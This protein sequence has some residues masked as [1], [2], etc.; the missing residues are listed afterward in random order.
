[1][2]LNYLKIAARNIR[3]HLGYSFINFAGLALGIASSILILVWV[4][5]EIG[6][7]RFHEK[8]D[9]LYVVRTIQHYGSQTVT[10]TGSVPALGPALKKEF[11]EVRNAAR[12]SNGQARYL[13][14]FGDKQFRETVQMADPELFE[15]FTFPLVR[16]NLR[17]LFASKDVMV[18]SESAAGRIFGKADPVGKTLTVDK[19]YDF[20]V[21]GVMKD[22]PANSTIRFDIWMPLEMT[23]RLYRPNYLDTWFNMAF[24]TYVELAPGT[25][26]AAFN[27]KIFDR[28]RQ[29][30]PQTI[31]E[32]L[33]YP[34]RDLYLKI[35]GRQESVRIFSAIAVLIL[36]IACIN[37]MNLTTA[38]S[39][40]RS[41]EVELRK[42]VGAD[43]RQLMRQF[44]GESLIFTFISL[45]L[46][47]GVI[48]LVLPA[49]RNLTAKSLTMTDL[50]QPSILASIVGIAF[51]T[52]I[53]AG[54]Y[55]SV[56]LSSFRPAAV[57]KGLGG[58]E[59][60]GIFFRKSLV[61]FQFTLTAVLMIGTL[62]IYSQVRYMKTK[63]LGFDREHLLYTP[64]EGVLGANVE[65]FKQELLGIPGVRSASA[66]THSPTGIYSN[67]QDWNWEGRDPNVNPLVTY[68][69]VDPDF[70]ETFQMNLAKGETFRAQ[71]SVTTPDVIIN[72]RLAAIIGSPDVIG[73]RLSQ[74]TRNMRIIG[75]VKDFHFKPVSQ[76]IEP[77]MI[78]Y[79][80]SYREFQA[81]RYMFVRLRPGDIRGTIAAIEKVVRERNPGFP[82]E[83]R[84]LNDDYDRLYRS[85]EREMAIVRI[86]TVLAILISCLGLFGLA[87]YT[88]EQRTKEIGIRKVLGATVPGIIALLSKEY[89][90]WVVIAD[91]IAVPVSFFLMRNWLREYAYRIPLSWLIFAAA[92]AATLV[93]AQVT[94]SWQAF[95]AARTNPADAVRYE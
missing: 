35:W 59:K 27:G 34:F 6:T 78:F 92:T 54:V 39:A 61:V 41:R 55:P 44:F 17:D 94:V 80:P 57:L 5:D 58:G 47:L 13:L 82:F 32:P 90:K 22:I 77:I 40:R 70:L 23:R 79:D 76:E 42:V 7:N 60:K 85:V 81:Y 75:I 10:G 16:G 56:F 64:I 43:R 8:A 88:A 89:A 72:E 14:E 53:L 86:F 11:P 4:K 9:S 71:A 38:R 46:A 12:V 15:L 93:L 2:I 50:L 45:L 20:R 66:T 67:G 28:I 91:F 63:S 83:Y 36:V 68:F 33:L 18:V 49:F 51:L 84:F 73:M 95:R 29:S 74:G 3:R 65:T 21:A 26:L 19:K 37:F 52:G 48:A 69:G 62:V 25:D 1:M 30:D 87:A 24:Q 31:L